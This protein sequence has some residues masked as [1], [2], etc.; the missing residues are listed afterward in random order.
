MSDI[1]ITINQFDLNENWAE[2]VLNNMTVSISFFSV[3][4]FFL[5]SF[6]LIL[7]INQSSNIVTQRVMLIVN[8]C[9]T[10]AFL[11]ISLIL[12]MNQ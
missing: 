10:K 5:Y 9:S 11:Q 4:F 3:F 7:S 8:L 12:L 2:V 6:L 1:N